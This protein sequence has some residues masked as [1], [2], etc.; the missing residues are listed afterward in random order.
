MYDSTIQ[1]SVAMELEVSENV[2]LDN[3]TRQFDDVTRDVTCCSW[4]ASTL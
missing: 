4:A 1:H 3:I 2:T